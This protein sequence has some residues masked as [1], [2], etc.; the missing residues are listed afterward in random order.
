MPP[1]QGV[2]ESGSAPAEVLWYGTVEESPPHSAKK[3][4]TSSALKTSKRAAGLLAPCYSTVLTRGSGGFCPGGGC[5]A[6]S[7]CPV[8]EV[9]L[10][11]GGVV[12]F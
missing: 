2:L 9:V 1:P 12:D 11:G 4:D 10:S 7:G 8:Q 6:G 5:C 3:L